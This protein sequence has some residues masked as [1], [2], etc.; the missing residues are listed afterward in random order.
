MFGLESLQNG[1]DV[2]ELPSNDTY[3]ILKAKKYGESKESTEDIAFGD[4]KEDGWWG[5]LF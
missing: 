4:G 2:E 3:G 1:R 5:G